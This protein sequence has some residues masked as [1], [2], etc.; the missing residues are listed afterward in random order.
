MQKQALAIGHWIDT[1]GQLSPESTS[2]ARH[3]QPFGRFSF[4]KKKKIG[5]CF[6]FF[7]ICMYH[8]NRI[9]LEIHCPKKSLKTVTLVKKKMREKKSLSK[10][11]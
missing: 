11:K 6:K 9:N 3:Q 2:S 5:V 1:L 8:K 10:N 7:S 4:K